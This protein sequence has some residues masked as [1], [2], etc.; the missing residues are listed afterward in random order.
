MSMNYGSEPFEYTIQADD[1]LW[2]IADDLNVSVEDIMAVNASLDPN[3]L[4]V[5]QVI[6]L[7][8]EASQ[9]RGG[10]RRGGFRGGF[11]G[12]YRRPYGYYGRPYY[13]YPYYPPYPYPPY[14]Y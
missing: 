3:Q 7:P 2:D 14:P 9:R 10:G 1:T 8:V 4:H 11:R 5:G 12:G 6:N 13:P